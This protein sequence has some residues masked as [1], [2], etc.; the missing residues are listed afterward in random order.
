MDE[1]LKMV[2]KTVRIT[3]MLKFFGLETGSSGGT[4]LSVEFAVPDGVTTK[5]F[6]RMVFE[7]KERLDT[8]ALYAE[9][10]KGSILASVF[11][12]RKMV[13]RESYD[14]LLGRNSP[15]TEAK[16]GPTS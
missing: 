2:P 6:K 9:A 4:E 13:L 5:D 1:P 7:E 15:P 16:S 12:S 8:M 10:A 11:D 3:S 14:R